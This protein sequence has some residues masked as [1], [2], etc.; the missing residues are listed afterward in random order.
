MQLRIFYLSS[1]NC[2]RFILLRI[3]KGFQGV[4]KRWGFKGQPAT[5]V[6]QKPTGGLELFQLV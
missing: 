5:H 3:G 4:M 1:Y 6:K 2:N